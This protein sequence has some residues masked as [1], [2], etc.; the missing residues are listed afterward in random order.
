MPSTPELGHRRGAVRRIEVL[1]E[2]EPKHQPEADSHVRV[3]TEIE[4]YLEGVSGGAVPRINRPDGA[5]VE[6][7]IG[8]SAARVGQQH[9][10]RQADA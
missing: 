4:V 8:Y 2:D 6:C 5:R 9:L 7:E 1:G 10:L 3:A